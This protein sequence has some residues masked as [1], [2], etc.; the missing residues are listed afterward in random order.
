MSNS[1]DKKQ[2]NPVG[3][4]TV[5]TPEVLVKLEQAFAIDSTVEEAL[6][7]AEIRK[8][9]YYDYLKEHPEFNE[10]IAELRQRPM[11]KARQTIVKSLDDPNHAFKYAEKKAK[12]EFGNAL[13]I[14]SKGEQIG[15]NLTPEKVEEI[16]RIALDE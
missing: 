7:Y 1:Q 6:S 16:N 5:M 10:R 8:D 13:D 9:P 4:P 11:L 14:T 2:S 3:R 12:K 15:A